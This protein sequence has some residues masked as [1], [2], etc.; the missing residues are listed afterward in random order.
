M[1]QA[2]ITV[3]R[4]NAGARLDV[5]LS[6][7]LGLTRSACQNLIE[8][9]LISV[10]GEIR[11]KNYKVKEGDRVRADLPEPKTVELA[12]Q[13]IPLDVVYE[14]DDIIVINK[15]KGLVVHPAPGHEDGTL[16]NA[17]MHHAGE[18]LSGING[19][20][21]PGIVHRI[22]K[23]TAGLLAVAKNDAAHIRLSE[24]LKEHKIKRR[25]LAVVLGRVKEDGTVSRPIGRSRADRKKMAIDGAAAREAV[26][27]YSVVE[28]LNGY[29]LL[30]C[31]LET[32]RTHQIRVHMASIG[33]PIAGDPLYGAKNDRSGEDGQLLCAVHLE[34]THPR[35][36]ERMEF[37]VEP[38]EYFTR[39]VLKKRER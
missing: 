17:L 11:P 37:D 4:E 25:Y 2:D 13:D 28:H 39:F 22:D 24:D 7:E 20:L 3:T 9:G 15:P 19:E 30:R 29:T 16:V 35:T 10:N 27:H 31:E 33:H 5:I 23:D 36:G 32:G 14:D 8:N 12:A 18:S 21:R 34:L 38:P 6:G 26:T 1:K